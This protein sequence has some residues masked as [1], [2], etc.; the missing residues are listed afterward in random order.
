VTAE[1]AF[2]FYRVYR[3]FFQGR[4][5]LVRYKGS[6]KMPPLIQQRDRVFYHKIANKLNDVQVH[7]LYSIIFFHNPTAYV[8]DCVTPE[9]FSAAV[10]FAA[11]AESGRTLL[12]A[13]CYELKKT[14][15]GVN[16]DD[17]LY[18]E[19]IEGVRTSMP[20]CMQMVISKAL[21][22]DLAAIL[23]LV[24][25]KA[26]EY[27]WVKWHRAQ[28]GAGLGVQAWITRL[29][30]LDQLVKLA[31]TGWRSMAWDISE[32]FWKDFGNL[33]PVVQSVPASLFD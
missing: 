19:K 7:A 5:D 30:A 31:R 25:Q 14:L 2:K 18:G 8:T 15:Q 33:A 1:T 17:W 12:D 6:M 16:L 28:P 11:R 3:L 24:P 9:A 10:A 29:Q 21:S 23:L 22:P 13:E 4:Y 32:K 20:E 27:E 26:Q